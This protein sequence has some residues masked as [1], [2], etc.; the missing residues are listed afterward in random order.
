MASQNVY[1]GNDQTIPSVINKSVIADFPSRTADL[2]I[3][4]V[5]PSKLL[6]V[7]MHATTPKAK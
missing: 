3:E 4:E 5:T 2:A 7:Y 6:I 1:E